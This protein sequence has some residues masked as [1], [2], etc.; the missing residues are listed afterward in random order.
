MKI[1]GLEERVLDEDEDELRGV[2]SVKKKAPQK[3]T[4]I[5]KKKKTK[6]SK[7]EILLQKRKVRRKTILKKG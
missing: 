1:K 4:A 5:L 3:K 2:P 7:K 6:P